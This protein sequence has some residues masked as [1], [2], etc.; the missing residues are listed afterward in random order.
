M[1]HGILIS[2]D[3]YDVAKGR[4]SNSSKNQENERFLPYMISG[5]AIPYL[6]G[7]SI[8]LK[9]YLSAAEQLTSDANNTFTCLHEASSLLEH[10]DTVDRT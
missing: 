9:R 2:K 7:A 6:Q 1:A 10:L 3:G 4:Q 8:S 5:I